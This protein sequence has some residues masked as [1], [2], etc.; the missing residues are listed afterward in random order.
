MEGR[1]ENNMKRTANRGFASMDR[2]QQ[3][4]IARKGGLTISQNREHMSKIGRKGGEKSGQI[5]SEKANKSIIENN[6]D[7]LNKTI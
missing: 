7:N 1:G 4:A 3:R 2:E 6:L 5:R